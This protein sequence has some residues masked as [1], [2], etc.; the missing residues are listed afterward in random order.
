MIEGFRNPDAQATQGPSY[1]TIET[2]ALAGAAAIQRLIA[3]RD[4]LRNHGDA[5]ERELVSL[6][7][8][9]DD[10]RRHITRI[11]DHYIRLA[12]EF[13]TQLKHFDE[14]IQV[15]VQKA[16]GA[17]GTTQ[18]ATLIS[19]AQRLSPNSERVMGAKREGS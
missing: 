5:Q 4:G 8:S 3:D 13:L 1:Q 12:T 11:R 16:Y 17:T 19:L 6:R 9:N 18:D 14:T 15:G 7:A 2:V 10:L